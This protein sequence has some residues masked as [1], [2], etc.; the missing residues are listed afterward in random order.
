MKSQSCES[1]FNLTQNART[2]ALQSRWNYHRSWQQI[3]LRGDGFERSVSLRIGLGDILP[4]ILQNRKEQITANLNGIVT[5]QQQAL[6]GSPGEKVENRSLQ[7]STAT[8]MVV[9]LRSH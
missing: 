7:P 6:R 5:T 2:D 9:D 8:H 1:T 4:T 3:I